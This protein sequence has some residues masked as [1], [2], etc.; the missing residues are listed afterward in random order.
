MSITWFTEPLEHAIHAAVGS[1]YPVEVSGIRVIVSTP[2]YRISF[3]CNDRDMDIDVR[4][5][6]ISV[7]EQSRTTLYHFA[8]FIGRE[9]EYHA[10]N[11]RITGT[12]D[13]PRA[14]NAVLAFIRSELPA[15]FDCSDGAGGIHRRL[16]GLPA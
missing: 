10:A 8:M 9:P 15:V 16:V 14:V 4:L 2:C 12:D 5:W 7:G 13:I 1:E 11:L 3:S 6:A